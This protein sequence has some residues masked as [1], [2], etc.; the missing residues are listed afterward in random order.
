MKAN[1]ISSDLTSRD[2]SGGSRAAGGL[3]FQADATAFLLAHLLTG[4]P[5]GGLCALIDS[6]PV[7]LRAETG[8]PG[9]DLYFVLAD[10]RV[11]EAQVKRG[12]R[13]GPDLWK[14]LLALAKGIDE[15]DIDFG[16]LLLCPQASGAIMRGL[17]RDLE[18]LGDGNADCLSPIGEE[19]RRQL[20]AAGLPT[21]TCRK[22]RIAALA[23]TDGQGEDRRVAMAHLQTIV[24]NSGD[25]LRAWEA[26]T[27]D[28]QIGRAVQQECRD[29]SRMPS[30]A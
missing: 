20:E 12:L 19:W 21:E 13:K 5:L 11:V 28:G 9:D 30:S 18:R 8:G 25:T 1:K 24:A 15:R 27:N 14:A 22:I 2:V 3:G 10:G 4:Q 16:L 17:A 6:A 26:L 29:R 23:I 7:V